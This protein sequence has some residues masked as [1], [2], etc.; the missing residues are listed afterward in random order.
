MTLLATL[1]GAEQLVLFFSQP[2]ASVKQIQNH[3]Q[4]RMLA[5][6]QA[7]IGLVS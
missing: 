6:Q 7:V 5:S 2:F 4:W 1:Y 3:D